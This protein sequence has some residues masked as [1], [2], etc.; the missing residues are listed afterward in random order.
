MAKRIREKF[1]SVWKHLPHPLRWAIV[2]VVGSI[3]VLVGVLF[4]F[5]P[6]PGIPLIVLGV[7]ILATEFAWAEVVYARLKNETDKFTARVKRVF[8]RK[9][10]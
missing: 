1:D 3:L 5:L 8:K 7:A 2:A 4:I 6:G 9:E 10:K